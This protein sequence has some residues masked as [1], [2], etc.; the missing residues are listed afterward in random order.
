MS[1]QERSFT[2]WFDRTYVVNLLQRRD[3]LMYITSEFARAGVH[4]QSSQVKLFSAIKPE[5]AEQFPSIGSRGCFFSHLSIL[6]ASV[7]DKV[8]RVLIVEDD[9]HLARPLI[10][11][12]EDVLEHLDDTLW[13]LAYLGH[14]L[15]LNQ[16][17]EPEFT[18]IHG[19]VYGAHF[20][21]VQ[22]ETIPKL[23]DFLETML[24]RPPGHPMGGPMHYDGAL[25][26]FSAQHPEV[27]TVASTVSLG[28]P[29]SSR[30]DVTPR[31]WD[32]YPILR[33]VSQALRPLRNW[34]KHV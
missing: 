32:R 26:T 3:R 7:R 13:G 6:R 29:S 14:S 19:E 28:N 16:V 18:Q 1:F 21:A 2:S 25:T 33:D 30:S 31:P 23:V 27:L 17:P 15:S 12:P 20:Y 9:L 8:E 11:H 24:T 22:G 10:E 5:S 34:M 4:V